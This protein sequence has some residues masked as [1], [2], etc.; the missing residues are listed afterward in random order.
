MPDNLTTWRMAVRA[1][2]GNTLVGEGT[3]ELISTQPLLLRPALPRFLRVGDSVDLRLL[4]RNAT[5]QESEVKVTLQAEGVD[6]SGGDSRT[7]KVPAGQSSIVSWPAKVTAE[8]T[9]KLT[10]SA[11][12]S[13]G[14]KDALVQELPIYLDVTPETMATGGIVTNEA[15]YEA[16]YLPPFAILKQGSLSV[17]VQSAL[18]GSM[19]DELK[20][21]Q[22]TPVNKEG[23]ERVASRLIAT[24]GVR[25]AEKSAR[26]SSTQYDQAISRDLAGLIGRQRTDG[27]WAWCDDPLCQTDPNVTGWA[28]LALGEARRDALSVDAGVVMRAQGYVLAYVNRT[29]DVAHPADPNQKAFLLAALAGA[30]GSAGAQSR[31]LFEQYR[32]ALANWGKAYL[33]LALNDSGV[34][35]DDAQ[36]RALLNDLAASTIPSANGNH[37][38][39]SPVRGSFMTNTATTGLVALALTRIQPE[40][41]L[42]A[43]T[44]R[45]L[46]VARGAERW[47]TSI[48]R[49]H[50]V[51]ALTEYAVKTGELAG[52]FSYSVTLDNKEILAGLV[53]PGEAPKTASKSLPLTGF[54]AGQASLVTFLRDFA[55]PGRLYYTLNLKYVTP[56]KDIEAVNRGFAIS[57]EYSPLDDP[58]KRIAKAKL[59]DTVRVKVTVMVPADRNYVVV[60]DLLPAGLEPIDPRLKTVD[61]KLK[62]QLEAERAAAEKA[63]RGGYYAPWFGWYFSP[64]QHVDTR[65]DRATL[66][67]DRL[68]KGVYEYIYYARATTPGDFFVAPAHAEETYFPEVFGRSDSGRFTVEP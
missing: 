22:L 59:G 17:S 52:N 27:G 18:A 35:K 48:E 32:T 40:Q 43:Q 49:A 25:R 38:E 66:F 26:G 21:A 55:N 29:T 10:F 46:V 1:V 24:I 7:V 19:A 50:A 4:V 39:D 11:S 15:A 28:L 9:A 12:G 31:A 53:K 14:L 36:V 60:D 33:L 68:P 67:A 54:T 57:H 37:W 41:P 6:V 45:W 3:N 44:V 61:P 51:V 8:G 34:A 5:K 64:W 56:A 20:S 47:S 42:V 30:G 65:D 2:S 23:A 58:S 63:R 16:V 62:A 13:G